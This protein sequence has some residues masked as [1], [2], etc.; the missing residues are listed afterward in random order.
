MES[1]QVTSTSGKNL[2]E[3]QRARRTRRKKSRRTHAR[4]RTE[5]PVPGGRQLVEQEGITAVGREAGRREEID[6]GHLNK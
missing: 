5:R 3:F 1:I 2:D 4:R 6:L